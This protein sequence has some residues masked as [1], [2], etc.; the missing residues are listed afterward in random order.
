MISNFAHRIHQAED[1]KEILKKCGKY[2]SFFRKLRLY[3]CRWLIN[4]KK[5]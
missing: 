2:K 5:Q 1:E 4:G 3:K